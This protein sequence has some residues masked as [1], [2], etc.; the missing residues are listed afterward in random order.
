MND[1]IHVGISSCLLGERVRFD[2]RHKHDRFITDT[3]GS[4]VSSM[5]RLLAVKADLSAPDPFALE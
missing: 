2:G 5:R 4:R 1:A 3:L